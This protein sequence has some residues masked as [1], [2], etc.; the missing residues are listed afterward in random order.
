MVN[1]FLVKALWPWG[2]DHMHMMKMAQACKDKE[3]FKTFLD[4]DGNLD[5]QH[6]LINCSLPHYQHSLK[7]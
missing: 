7:M 2:L 6:S 5:H 1:C 3:S 4:L